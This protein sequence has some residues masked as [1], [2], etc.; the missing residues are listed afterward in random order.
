MFANGIE[1]YNQKME[2]RNKKNVLVR[3]V[4]N[5]VSPIK[6]PEGSKLNTNY[7]EMKKIEQEEK[8][9]AEER[10][11]KINNMS[12]VTVVE[13]KKPSFCKR[14]KAKFNELAQ[15][16]SRI[17]GRSNESVATNTS[18]ETV[19]PVLSVNDE[20]KAVLMKRQLDRLSQQGVE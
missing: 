17:I 19:K 9:L 7:K 14:V 3:F 11:A 8:R 13:V 12:L 18:P 20:F 2:K 16:M 5:K 4:L 15:N 6:A 10:R 1:R